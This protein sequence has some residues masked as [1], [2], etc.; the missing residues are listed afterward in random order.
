MAAAP[1]LHGTRR[2]HATARLHGTAR[3]RGITHLRR[4]VLVATLLALGLASVQLSSPRLA[5]GSNGYH[6]TGTTTYTV[7]PSK[8]RL[9]VVIDLDFK[10]TSKS[11]STTYYVYVSVYVWLEHAATHVGVTTNLRGATIEKDKAGQGFD[12]WIIHLGRA[13]FYGE[14]RKIHVTYQLLGGAPRSASFVRINPAFASFCVAAAGDDGGTARVVAPLG[15][16]MTIEG[17]GGDLTSTTSGTWTTWSTGFLALPYDFWACLDGANPA[18]YTDTQLTSPSGQNIDLQSW[19][20]DGTWLAQ[21]K[22]E[23]DGTLAKLEQL[24]GRGLP[25][26]GPIVVREVASTDLG[27]YAGIFDPTT[28]LARVGEEYGSGGTVAHELSHAWFNDSLFDGRWL[29]EGM[30]EWARVSVV[31]DTCPEPGP[32][33]GIGNP[34]LGVWQFAGPKAT[35]AELE[36]VSYQYHAACYIVTTLAAKIGADGMRAVLAALFDHKV[37][38]RSGKTV[39][40]G[41]SAPATWQTWLDAIDELGMVPAGVTDLDVAQKLLQKYGIANVGNVLDKRSAARAA[42]HQLGSSL[43][44]WTIPEAILR[45]MAAWDFDGATKAMAH[46]TAIH[47]SLAHADQVLQGLGALDGPIAAAFSAAKTEADLA[48]VERQ[49]ADQAAAADAVAAAQAGVATPRDVFTTLGL[50][51]VDLDA[52]MAA[53][54]AGARAGDLSN[55]KAQSA[56]IATALTGASQQGVTRVAIVVAVTLVLLLLLILIIRRQRRRSRARL[57]I[58]LAAMPPP[59]ATLRDAGFPPDAVVP[60]GPADGRN[61]TD[62]QPNDPTSETRHS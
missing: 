39:L 54:F 20:T 14:T 3:L 21:V 48:A 16:Q 23:V 49:A 45:P 18:G 32:Y 26:N 38:Y 15:Y 43:G 8:G 51:G 30:A 25:R 56:A 7:N 52:P 12:R 57:A 40:D 19:P 9:D 35:K 60:G 31:P 28:G 50:L 5:V 42:Y 55:A 36:A 41:P 10:N 44:D 46:A 62:P 27:P 33:P 37:A 2:L 61:V 17:E 11:T 59:D 47:A 53:A 1:R 4:V 29:S 24:V 34:N 58:A 6:E 22:G 13:I